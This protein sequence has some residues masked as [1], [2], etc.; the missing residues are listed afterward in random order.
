MYKDTVTVFNFYGGKWF[1]T[2]IENTELQKTSGIRQNNSGVSSSDNALLF[3]QCQDDVVGGKAYLPPKVWQKSEDKE[4]AVTFSEDAFFVLG[5]FSELANDEDYEDGYFAHM[6][7]NC[8]YCYKITSVKKFKNIP[9]F[10][11]GGA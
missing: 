5:E 6:S 4:N 7:E 11:I 3:V 2:V 10:E 9:H 8:D 1:P